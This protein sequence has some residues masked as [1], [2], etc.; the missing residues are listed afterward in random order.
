MLRF[1]TPNVSWIYYQLWLYVYM[2]Y[3]LIPWDTNSSNS[4]CGHWSHIAVEFLTKNAGPIFK[5]SQSYNFRRFPKAGPVGPVASNHS[6]GCRVLACSSP[7]F[8]RER[9]GAEGQIWNKPLRVE[10]NR[11]HWQSRQSLYYIMDILLIYYLYTTYILLIYSLLLMLN[12]KSTR[13]NHIKR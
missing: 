11:F 8:Q 9:E 3:Y 13:T 10:L 6:Q 4:F 7:G 1:Q 12:H 2:V 5:N